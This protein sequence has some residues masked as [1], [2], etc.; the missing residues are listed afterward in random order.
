MRWFWPGLSGEYVPQQE[1]IAI[2]ELDLRH[3]PSLEVRSLAINSPHYDESTLIWM[4]RNRMNVHNLQGSASRIP[5]MK[6]RGFQVVIGGHNAVLPQAVLNAHPE[7]MAEYGGRRQ[8]PSSHPPHLCWSNPGVQEALAK[9]IAQ[10][11]DRNPE[12][13]RVRFFGAD[14]THFCE[15]DDC[16]AYA[17]DVS[18]RWQKFS[19]TVIELVNQTH[20]GKKYETLAYQAYRDVPTEVAPFDMVGY[21]T[22]NINYTKPITDASNAKVREEIK[23]W[24]DLGVPVGIRGYQ[25]INFNERMLSPITSLIVEEIAWAQQQG[26]KGWTSEVTPFG[27]P[28]GTLPQNQNWVTNRMPLYAAAQAMW[29]TE[30]KP[31]EIM[32]DWAQHVFGPAANAMAAYYELMDHAWRSNPQQLT[33]FLQPPSGF[34]STFISSELLQKADGYFQLARQA[35]GS[36][37]DAE[38]RERIEAQITL[39]AAMLDKWR[40]DYL[41]QQGRAARFAVYAPLATVKPAMDGRADDPA[42]KHAARLPSFEDNQGTDA[43]EATDAYALWDERALYLRFVNHDAQIEQLR[44]TGEHH[45]ASMF[46]DDGIEFF[47][48]DPNHPAAY[49]HMVA[50]AKGVRYDARSDGT[51]DFDTSCDPVWTAKTSIGESAWILDVELPFESFGIKRQQAAKGFP[52]FSW[53]MSFKR[54]GASRRPNTGW[55]D[56]SYHNTAGFGTVTLVETIPE[57][58]RLLLYDVSGKGD[59]MRADA[60]GAEL[61]KLGFTTAKVPIGEAELISALRGGADVVVLRHPSGSRL[62]DEFANDHLGPFLQKGGMVLMA[63]TG[64]IPFERWFG[65][66]AAVQ[67]GGWGIHPNR[68]TAWHDNGGWQRQPHALSTVIEKRL[69]PSSG[70]RPLTDAWSVMARMRMSNDEL[71]SYLLRLDIG[72]GILYLTSSNLGYSGGHEMFGSQNPANA[73]MLID[74]LL[75]AHRQR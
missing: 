72:E 56:A 41:L 51:M 54:S 35:L 43:L 25:F 12:I 32:R 62:S 3:I 58:K 26:L 20:P 53:K 46:G 40:Q 29:N 11:W 52:P 34:A 1:R 59:P 42:W 7:Y 27:W 68:V 24:Q 28:V 30:I 15:C 10:W 49:F 73:A 21:T 47:L 63:A 36:V 60:L 75:A 14:H 22:Y 9:V 44:I 5:P 71:L 31:S 55:P 6:R 17:P 66:G 18:T 57:Q 65:P 38:T 48:A 74:N 70:Y 69:T 19:R 2:E 50:N 37:N 8:K 45:D 67:W 64:A 16:L 39:E 4:A 61:A 13:D 23:A 33:Y